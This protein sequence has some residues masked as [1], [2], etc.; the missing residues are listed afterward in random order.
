MTQEHFEICLSYIINDLVV[1]LTLASFEI[2]L[3]KLQ[4]SQIYPGDLH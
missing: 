2:H 1:G 3:G 4:G